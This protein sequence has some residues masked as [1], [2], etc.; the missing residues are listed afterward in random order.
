MKDTV[1]KVGLFI[2]ADN[3]TA[4]NIDKIFSELAHYG[5]VNIRK[6]YGNWKNQN[7]KGWEDILHQYAIQPV[8]QFDL[9]KGKNATDIA[10]VIDV[11]DDL[12]TKDLDVICLVSSDCDFTRLA[13]RLIADGKVV[14]GAGE[15]QTPTPFVHCCSKF[16]YLDNE[17]ENIESITIQRNN[18]KDDTRLVN[19]LRQA[20]EATKGEDGWSGLP[21]LGVYISTIDPF[22]QRHCGFKKLSDLLLAVGLFDL[23]KINR[24]ECWVRNKEY[25]S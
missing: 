1:A 17:P 20:V 4:K 25:S 16:L 3:V 11:M 13:T 2:D 19:I 24:T 21:Q 5:V 8:Q 10:L 23:K 14:I 7:L 22:E 6:A 18:L 15:S 12:Y 9:I